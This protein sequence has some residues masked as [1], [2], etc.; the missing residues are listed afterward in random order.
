MRLYVVRHAD[1]DY[2]NNTITESGHREARA[3]AKR[4]RALGLS[5][6]YSSPLGRAQDTA[7]YTATVT[8][9][10]VT[11]LPWTA[12]LK[13]EPIED[14]DGEPTAAWN[15]AGEVVRRG[16]SDWEQIPELRRYDHRGRQQELADASDSFLAGL[17][18]VRED[19]IYKVVQPNVES[20]AVFCH[21]GFA[22]S[23]L[24]HLLQ[25]LVPLGWCGFFLAPS[26][27]T[28]VLMEIRSAGVAV[29]R[30]LAVGDTSHVYA[31][32]LPESR[33]GLVANDH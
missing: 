12:E 32:G 10:P 28:T 13:V 29:P 4:M 11:T 5:R 30:V 6:I 24:A 7:R 9:L 23:W 26:S 18:Y 15:V 1:P 22:V 8:G 21:A 17:G 20:V 2:P 16:G 31:E 3:L 33:R 25:L 14:L 19:G 27:V